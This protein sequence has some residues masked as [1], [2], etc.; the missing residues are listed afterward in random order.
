MALL[1]L[2]SSCVLARTS[3]RA[4]R[5]RAID[6][7]SVLAI[8]VGT[9]GTKACIVSSD[10][11]I[12]ASGF[13]A[14]PAPAQSAMGGSC[15]MEQDPE[16]WWLATIQ[17]VQ[18]CVKKSRD[19]GADSSCIQG[20]SVTGQMQDIVILPKAGCAN[21]QRAI[22][23]SDTRA[24]K[25]VIEIAEL[26]GG[27]SLLAAMTGNFQ[28]AS[29]VLAKL[30][31]IDK[32]MEGSASFCDHLLLGGHDFV[33]WKLCGSLVT[34]VTTASTTGLIDP[35]L[36][37]ADK[38]IETAGLHH[39]IEKFPK[40]FP[41]DVPCDQPGKVT[42]KASDEL[43]FP[44]LRALP[45]L[46]SCG[47]AGACT[48]GAGAS[49]PGS[50]YVYLGTSGWVAGSFPVEENDGKFVPGVFTLGHPDSSLVFKTGSIMTAGGNLAWAAEK[51]T[52][53]NSYDEINKLV[54]TASVGCGG[55]LY[56]PFLNGE[57]CPMDSPTYR[58]AFL[59]ISETTSRADML[60]AVMEGVAFALL[61]AKKAMTDKTSNESAAPLRLVGG[62]AR[63]ATWPGIIAGVF[64]QTVEVLSDPQDVGVKGA[65]TLAGKY[66]GWHSCLSPPGN[67]LKYEDL[68]EPSWS[69][70]EAY[71][72]LYLTYCKTCNCL[73]GVFNRLSHFRD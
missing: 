70:V 44:E 13:A 35:S 71:Q 47:D 56:L 40:I 6:V 4:P 48:L 66:F 55:L 65:A 57:R 24:A 36:Q 38:L 19:D 28:G 67:W 49:S 17:A 45:V 12:L 34:D 62:G 26:V 43:G 30:R 8:D 60:R 51:L 63:S 21:K 1:A 54:A 2:S 32:H 7:E 68:Y 53:G 73:E 27:P 52:E 69:D 46:H 50:S 31:W 59:G 20:I 9:G 33:T 25:E 15:S 61:S 41:P 14:H 11:D 23:Y 42:T 64:G 16:L 39:W 58:A 18:S 10:G 72:E 29:S 3:L 37:Y 22:L 5:A